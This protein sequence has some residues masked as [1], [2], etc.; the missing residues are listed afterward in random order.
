M[1]FFFDWR[2][3]TGLTV[4][5]F[6]IEVKGI[7]KRPNKSKGNSGILKKSGS[8]GNM[9]Q[10]GLRDSLEITRVHLQTS[11]E[12]KHQRVRDWVHIVCNTDYQSTVVPTKSDSEVILCLQLLSKTLRCTLHLS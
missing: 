4:F 5:L 3:K 1:V 11:A 10:A 12:D 2:L 8:T 7:L 6:S 9:R